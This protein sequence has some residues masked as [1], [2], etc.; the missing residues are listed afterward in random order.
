MMMNCVFDMSAHA[1]GSRKFRSI[2]PKIPSD[3]TLSDGE[4]LK[5]N[6][7]RYFK[8]KKPVYGSFVAIEPETGKILT[9]VQYRRGGKIRN[10]AMTAAFPAASVFKIVSAAAMLQAGVSPDT[11]V[12]YTGGRRGINS[13]HLRDRK[14]EKAC[15]NLDS[16]FAHSTNAVFAKLA[17]RKLTADSIMEMADRFG[18]G[19]TINVGDVTTVSRV[20]KPGSKL[21]LARMAAGFSNSSLSAVHGAVVAAVVA[22][23]GKWPSEV[24]FSKSK[25]Q[26]SV[27]VVSPEIAD[28]L[29]K[30]MTRAVT[31]GTATRYLARI[32]SESGATAAVKTGS[33]TSKDGS[34]I[35]NNWFVGFYPSDKPEIAF[36]VH[37][38]HSWAGGVKAGPAAKFA[39]Q[40]WQAIR[41]KR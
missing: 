4:I 10:P 14:R 22:N 19:N 38:G 17:S 39:L 36:A 7:K 5:M 27:Q 41:K 31:A 23:R 3:T 21:T 25:E 13:S 35:W 15:R 33:L 24:T 16:A 29:R 1:A 9:L 30:M 8:A 32:K 26:R 28:E 40:T 12:C 20:R 6:M 37:I 34:K 18:F 11:R 2:R